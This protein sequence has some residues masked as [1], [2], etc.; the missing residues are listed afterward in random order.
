MLLQV[1][2]NYHFT[3][4]VSDQYSGDTHHHEESRTQEGTAG[5]YSVK[6]PDG[7]TQV[8]GISLEGDRRPLITNTASLRESS[9]VLS[10]VFR[11]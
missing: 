9:S 1:P 6:L 3:Y 11:L 7:R 5:Q 2:T 10:G 4:S 8:R